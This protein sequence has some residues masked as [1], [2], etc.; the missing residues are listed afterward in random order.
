MLFVPAFFAA[1]FLPRLLTRF[2]IARSFL[3]SFAV[4]LAASADG[5]PMVWLPTVT[6]SRAVEGAGAAFV[7]F[8]DFATFDGFAAFRDV[9]LAVLRSGAAFRAGAVFLRGRRVAFRDGAATGSSAISSSADESVRSVSD[10]GH[11]AGELIWGLQGIIAEAAPTASRRRIGVS[12]PRA[13]CVSLTGYGVAAIFDP[14]DTQRETRLVDITSYSGITVTMTDKVVL[15][16]VVALA[17]ALP[18]A[19]QSHRA[20]MRGLVTDSTGAVLRGAHVEATQRTTNERRTV[21]TDE[22]GRFAVP[23]LP[24]GPYVVEITLAGYRS[25]TTRAELAVGEELWL[26]VPLNPSIEQSVEVNAPLVPIERDSAAMGT[27]IDTR[28]I[29]GLPLD[30][31]NFLE[32]TLLAPGTAPA[33]QGS[34]SSVRGDFAFTVNGAREDANAFLLDGVYNVD[35]KLGTTG[36]RPSVDAIR[37]FEILTSTYDASFGRNAG[38]QVNVVTHSG[39]NAVDGTAYGFFRNGGLDAKNYFAPADAADPDYDR[40]QFGVSVGGPLARDRAFFFVDYEG[41]RLDEGI[42]RVTNVPTAA[43]RSGDFSQSGFARPVDPFTRQPF[44]G[45][46]LPFV[47]PIGASIAALYPLPNRAMPLANYVSSPTLHDNGDQFDLRVDHTLSGAS[48]LTGRYSFGDR[49]LLEPFAGTGFSTVP[50]FGNEVARRGQNLAVSHTTTL[51]TTMLNDVRFGYNRVAIGVFPENPAIDNASVGL[52]ALSTA[53]RDAGMSLI[54]VAGFATLGH[55]Y[56]NPQESASNTCQIA[57]TLTWMRGAHLLK[58]GGEYY[59]IRQSA[60]RDVQARGFL[61]FVQQGYTGNALA[62]LLLGL[63]VLTGGARLDNPQNLRT[64]SWSGFV[65]DDWRALPA[66]TVSAGLRYDYVTPPVDKDDRATLYDVTTGQLVPVGSGNVPRG[67]FETDRN[68]IA[69]RLGFAWTLDAAAR[70]VVRGGYGIYY[71]Q[72]ALATSEGLYFNPPYF[73]LSVLFPVPGFPPLTVDDP[74]RSDFPFPIPQSATTYQP[75]LQTPWMEHWNVNVQRQLGATRAIEMAYV[76]S[77]GH[78][79]ISA[80][81]ANQPPASPNPVTLRPNPLFSDITLIESRASSKYDALQLKFQQRAT[82][83]L[84]LLA[85]YTLGKSTD[86]ASGFFTS[87][88]D[89]NFPQDSRNPAAERA[90]SAFDVRHRLSVSAAYALPFSGN[91]WIEDWEVQGILTLQSG[92]PFTVAV[93]PDIDQSNTGR[94]NLG[95]GYNDRPNVSGDPSV[96]DPTAE[97]WFNTTAFSFA[98]FGSFGNAGRNI[99]DGPGYQNVNLAVIKHLSLG[100]DAR[101]QLRAETFN[102]LNHANLDLPD[103]FLGSPTFGQILSAQSPRRFQFGIKALF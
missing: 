81:D 28:Q 21:T 26:D 82:R 61:T 77:R 24:V 71:N 97:R 41:T 8:D 14:D 102:V 50:G 99:L 9:D 43:E 94:S 11:L 87:T 18:A 68:N 36:V 52:P 19:A 63:P 25:H 64:Q 48:R 49:R 103:A 58:A 90:R 1:R 15:L 35:P 46:R 67:G 5:N 65:H 12:G 2:K 91:D 23:E 66:L 92:R 80:R 60:Y 57:D 45:D 42:T 44:A 40:Q 84:S 72:G 17:A 100:G 89:A 93:H 34:A 70:T 85:A 83:G 32:L 6:S 88:G 16:F 59:G 54:S 33:P 37:E 75:D 7:D 31:R 30:G 53:P 95:F 76:G 101:L 10:T 4:K 22:G 78:D 13:H 47:H 29:S 3:T 96:D 20:S 51:G 69:P 98:P 74:F 56:N 27:L 55:E 38:G 39:T 79:L 62:D 86:D 73:N